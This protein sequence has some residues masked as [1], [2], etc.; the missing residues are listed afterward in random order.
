MPS[1]SAT[2][3]AAI[4]MA[5]SIVGVLGLDR[6]GVVDVAARHHQHVQ[7]APP[8]VMSRKATV[9]SVLCTISAGTS[10]ATIPQKRQSVMR[11][12]PCV[13]AA[14]RGG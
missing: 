1:A 12:R 5:A 14:L 13:L 11:S 3:R 2:S 6:R 10:P 9:R 7:R 4:T 8:G